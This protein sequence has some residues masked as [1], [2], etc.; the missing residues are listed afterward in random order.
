MISGIV[1]GTWLFTARCVRIMLLIAEAGSRVRIDR[2]CARG[3]GSEGRIRVQYGVQ[4]RNGGRVRDS[5]SGKMHVDRQ[6]CF[7]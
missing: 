3:G 1:T 2:V 7:F 6:A 5:D 4:I